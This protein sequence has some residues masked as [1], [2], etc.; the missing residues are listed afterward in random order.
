MTKATKNEPASQQAVAGLFCPIPGEDQVH[1][2]QPQ[3]I[4]LSVGQTPSGRSVENRTGRV[5]IIVHQANLDNRRSC[6]LNTPTMKPAPIG[7]R[8][9]SHGDGSQTFAL[10][11]GFQPLAADIPIGFEK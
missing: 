2:T 6:P 7:A 3:I 5:E 8:Q 10:Q 1:S 4:D 9:C 11:K